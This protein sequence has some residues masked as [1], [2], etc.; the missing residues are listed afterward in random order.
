VGEFLHH[1]GELCE[2]VVRVVRARRSFGMILNAEERQLFVAHSL[3]GVVVEVDVGD[4]NIAG[5][6][7]FGIDAEAVILRGDLDFLVLKILHGM[8][9]A[10]VAKFQF[11]GFAA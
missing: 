6:K 2:K 5:R 8:I 9:G 1:V 3:V 10:V 4:L 11:E 7:R